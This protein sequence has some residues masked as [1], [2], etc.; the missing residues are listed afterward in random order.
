MLTETGYVELLENEDTEES[1][2]R[3]E[4]INE[5]LNALTIWN[6]ENPQKTL[7][8]FLEEISLVSDIDGWKQSGNAVN[9]MTLH[10]AKGLEFK[11]IFLVGLEDG[12]IPSRQ[13]FDDELKLEEEC[14]LFYVG[15][16]RAQEMLECSYVDNRMRFGM[17]MPMTPSRFIDGVP[18]ALYR[19]VDQSML[20]TKPVKPIRAPL[21]KKQH[22]EKRK[23]REF[24]YQ[25]FYDDFSQETV[26]Y[27]MGQMVAH[28]K[29]GQGKILSISGFGADMRLT[30][31]F[32]DGSRKQMMAKFANLK[33]L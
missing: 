25:P 26:Q 17:Y 14:R 27:R 24:L 4:N 16:T 13:N 29:Y 12:L 9:L 33:A 3:L 23:N 8:D 11:A 15:S 30:I 10:C 32:H 18:P 19:F 6:E 2:M 20:F 7:T 22:A 5:L 28:N 1:R 21:R 31:L